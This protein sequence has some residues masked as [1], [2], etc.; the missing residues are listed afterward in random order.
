[1]MMDAS[2]LGVGKNQFLGSKFCRQGI[3]T[4]SYG[5][6]TKSEIGFKTSQNILRKKTKKQTGEDGHED[7]KKSNRSNMTQFSNMSVGTFFQLVNKP[8]LNGSFMNN[9]NLLLHAYNQQA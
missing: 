6:G 7:I 8:A 4:P 1:M 2:C 5:S 9:N 3:L